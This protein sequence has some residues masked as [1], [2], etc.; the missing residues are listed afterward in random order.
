MAELQRYQ[1]GATPF[2][3]VDP[4]AAKAS[5]Q[6]FQSLSTRLEEWNGIA[7]KQAQEEVAEEGRQQ[8]V[9]DIVSGKPEKIEKGY[10]FYSKAYNDVSKAAFNVRIESDLKQQAEIMATEAG[11]DYN[12][13]NAV[14]SAFAKET[15]KGIQEPEFQALAMQAG[16]KLLGTYTANIAKEKF[17]Q[18]RENDIK[19]IDEGIEEY[20]KNYAVSYTANDEGEMVNS[21]TKVYALFQQKKSLGLMTDEQIGREISKTQ[22]FAEKNKA[23]VD[24][25]KSLETGDDSFLDKF[26]QSEFYQKADAG[27]RKELDS[28]F[29]EQVDSYYK[30]KTAGF[31]KQAKLIEAVSKR[32]EIKL[33][34]DIYSGKEVNQQTL[35]DMVADGSITP[36]GSDAMLQLQQALKSGAK[37]SD[38]KAVIYYKLH[39]GSINSNVIA[40]DPRLSYKDKLTYIGENESRKSYDRH[41][42]AIS[43][44]AKQTK[45][46]VTEFKIE[47]GSH[48][49]TLGLQIVNKL[50]NFDAEPEVV[51]GTRMKMILEADDA[52]DSGL[53]TPTQYPAK[54][55]QIVGEW[56]QRN[57][58]NTVSST[59]D[60]ENESY[61]KAKAQY[62]KDWN[63][64]WNSLVRS[65][66]TK[67]APP[68]APKKPS[69]YVEKGNRVYE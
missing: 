34:K 47:K 9:A 62:D 55:R 66:D 3:Q 35:D 5:A 14:Y 23:S 16:Q 1:G 24:H 36:A 32:N 68:K 49:R 29:N 54:L 57:I 48:P 31:E 15:V 58:D 28:M 12:K 53:I 61:K 13:F 52:L 40:N 27:L 59:Y 42:A 56:K 26:E 17:K 6:M 22:V 10:T 63:G 20:K 65:K 8:A 44:S 25:M 69:N 11:T 2:Q 64:P 19:S 39:A 38:G 51:N 46:D 4:T 67:Y 21:I 60:T 45:Q 43:A 37:V 18:Q 30:K 33:A 41:T 7:Y 50:V